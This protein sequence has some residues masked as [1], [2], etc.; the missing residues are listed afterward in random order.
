MI[1]RGDGDGEFRVLNNGRCRVGDGTEGFAR[2]GQGAEPSRVKSNDLSLALPR[3]APFF[4]PNT[5][6]DTISQA[7]YEE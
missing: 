6:T 1:R 7:V 2:D 4:S 5:T 3:D